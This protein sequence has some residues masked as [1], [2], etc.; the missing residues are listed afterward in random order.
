MVKCG[1]LSQAKIEAIDIASMK[2]QF[3]KSGFGTNVFYDNLFDEADVEHSSRQQSVTKKYGKVNRGFLDAK[4]MK[5]PAY[6]DKTVKTTAT[7]I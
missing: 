4:Q 7:T 1:A 2:K 5:F 3:R 6:C